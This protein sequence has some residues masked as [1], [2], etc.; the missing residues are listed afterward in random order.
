MKTALAAALSA[1]ALSTPAFAQNP[2]ALS[3]SAQL[4]GAW[5]LTAKVASVPY[6]LV[7]RFEQS[8]EDVGG[9]CAD[10]DDGT[11]HKLTGGHIDGDK[12]SFRH[13]GHFMFAKFDVNY[14]GVV[15]GD[16]MSGQIAVFGHTGAFTAVRAE[17]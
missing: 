2:G 4:A 6:D 11:G 12:V 13:R 5:R 10:A 15:E 14:A 8:G 16:H 7:C 1:I 17:R 9:V 3:Q